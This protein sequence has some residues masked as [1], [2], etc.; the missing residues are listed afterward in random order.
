[1]IKIGQ[2][3]EIASCEKT[4]IFCGRRSQYKI[5]DQFVVK[6]IGDNPRGYGKI[7]SDDDYNFIHE[8]D[9]KYEFEV[10]NDHWT[11]HVS[12]QMI[13]QCLFTKPW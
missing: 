6:N 1:M 4:E 11:K 2:V 8:D 13:Y 3:V 5:G 7:L 12:L 10:S 9:V